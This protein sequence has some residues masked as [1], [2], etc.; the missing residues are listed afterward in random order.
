MAPMDSFRLEPRSQFRAVEL[1][2]QED[3]RDKTINSFSIFE[4]P[5]CCVSIGRTYRTRMHRNQLISR[6]F[7]ISN[8]CNAE[9]FGDFYDMNVLISML[10][11]RRNRNGDD[12][13]RGSR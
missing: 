7:L 6:G 10:S 11:T 8:P 2:I 3:D 5:P 12:R 4:F 1:L 13:C 9:L